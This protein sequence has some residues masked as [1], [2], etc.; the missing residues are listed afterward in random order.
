MQQTA[1]PTHFPSIS[2]ESVFSIHEAN[3]PK[4]NLNLINTDG[5]I[6]KIYMR[7]RSVVFS[8]PVWDILTFVTPKTTGQS[9]C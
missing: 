3:T 2:D 4:V 8:Q 9:I 7:Q 1:L 5:A 6:G